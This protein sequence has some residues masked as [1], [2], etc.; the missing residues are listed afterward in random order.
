MKA[1]ISRAEAPATPPM[2][3]W[4]RPRRGRFPRRPC[5]EA[6]MGG[7]VRYAASS[8]CGG[9]VVVCG[10]ICRGTVVGRRRTGGESHESDKK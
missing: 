5:T 2:L 6:R 7:G 3:E 10:A 8:G 9:M 1:F 4:K